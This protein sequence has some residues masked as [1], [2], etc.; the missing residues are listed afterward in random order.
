MPAMSGS[1]KYKIL[2]VDDEPAI[3]GFLKEI[4]SED[5]YEVITATDG[6]EALPMAVEQQPDLIL[7][8][9]M[10]P[11][12]DGMETCRRLG[13]RPTTPGIR[14]I[15]LTAYDTRDRVDEAETAGAG[16]FFG[17]ANAI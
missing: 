5:G 6:L 17:T 9:I 15:T 16:C 10:M 14:I 11:N 8:D 4:L 7:L 12:L 3:L 2:C 13:E 1:K